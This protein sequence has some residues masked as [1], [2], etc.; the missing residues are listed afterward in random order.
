MDENKSV[1]H[2]ELDKLINNIV[3]ATRRN[4]S[5]NL[6]TWKNNSSEEL[7][8]KNANELIDEIAEMIRQGDI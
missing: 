7:L 4:I 2:P 6:I 8:Y 5:D 1:R 3:S